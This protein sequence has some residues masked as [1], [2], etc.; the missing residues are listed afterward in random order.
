MK[1]TALLFLVL[2]MSSFANAKTALNCTS[3]PQRG[4]AYVDLIPQP[5]NKVQISV[6]WF[7]ST[8]NVSFKTSFLTELHPQTQSVIGEGKIGTFPATI[9]GS[10]ARQRGVVQL[11]VSTRDRRYDWGYGL[12]LVCK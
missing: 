4:T 1:N 9:Q 8:R 2:L 12:L 5:N 6:Y 11:S 7:S 10:L 3:Y